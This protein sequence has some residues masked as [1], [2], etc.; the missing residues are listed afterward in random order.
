MSFSSHAIEET[1]TYLVKR[2]YSGVLA[3][4]LTVAFPF[5]VRRTWDNIFLR[6]IRGHLVSSSVHKSSNQLLAFVTPANRTNPSLQNR[7]IRSRNE[8]TPFQVR[9]EKLTIHRDESNKR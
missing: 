7:T 2:S 1:A 8:I 9:H 5:E 4:K 6:T 3:A